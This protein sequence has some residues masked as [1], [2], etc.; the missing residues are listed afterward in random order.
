VALITGAG[1]RR[2]IAAAVARRL[3][4][5]GWDLGL[6]WWPAGD[7]G[8]PWAGP[9]GEPLELAEELGLT[10]RVAWHEADLADPAAPATLFDAIAG[11]LGPVQALVCSHAR[12]R[13]GGVLDT[14]A[15]DFDAHVA[16]NARATLLLIR[17]LASRLPAGVP[18]RVVS[19]TSDALHGEVAYGASKAALE[20]VTVAAAIE[21]APRGITVNAVKPGPDRHGLDDRG[22]RAAAGAAHPGGPD[23]PARRRCGAG[24]LPLLAV[25]PADR[26]GSI[27]TIATTTERTESFLDEFQ[28]TLP[29]PLDPFQREAIEKLDRHVG[30]LVSAPTS[31]GKTVVA[32]YCNFRALR[33]GSKVIYTTPLKALSNQKF[34]DFQRQY[35]AA[36]VG[37]VTGENTINDDAPIVVMT[38]EILRNLIYEDVER[39][40]LVRYVVLDEVHYID[41]FPRGSVWEEVIIQAPA[42]V[43]FVGLSATIGNYRELARWMSENRGPVATVFHEERPTELR[44]WLAM[45]NRFHPLFNAQ[46]AIEQETWARAA[47]DDE[48]ANL[49]GDY[50]RLP[51]NDM[52]RVIDELRRMEML[53]A[54]YF[55]FSRRGCR[56]AL[57]RCSYHELD[58]TSDEEKR[59]IDRLTSERLEALLDADEAALFRRMVDGN[60]LR[61]GLAVHHAGLLPYHKE[62]VEELF[63]AGLVKVVFATETL[64]LGINMPAKAVV[65][66]SFTKFDGVSFSTLTT[67]ELTQL[68]GRAGRRGIDVRGHGVILKEQDVDIATIY[69]VAMGEGLVVESKFLP[70]YNMALNLL[71]L[72]TPPQAEQLML[73]SFGQYQKRLASDQLRERI[74]NVRSRLSDLDATWDCDRCRPSE[75]GEYYQLED[76]LRAVRIEVRRLRR[77]AV[78]VPRRK[79]GHG[80]YRGRPHGPAGRQLHRLE[81]ERKALQERQ[82]KLA[83]VRCP[84]FTEHLARYGERRE[85]ERELREGE[86]ALAEQGDL[87]Q[88]KFRRLCRVL[89]DTGFIEGDKPTEKGLLAARVYGENS[90]LVT[91]A[92][93]LGWFDGLQPEELCALMVMLTAE[94][95]GRDRGPRPQR[96]SPTPAI[97]QTARLLR[98]LYFRFA[99]LESDLDEP[100]LRPPSHDYIDFAYRWASGEPMDSIPLPPNV[101]IGDAIK[102][103]KGLYS[104]LRQTEFALRAADSPLRPTVGAAVERMERDVIRRT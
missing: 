96:R 62:L 14:T 37:L 7:A 16:V 65:V 73:R 12:S 90:L 22:R 47:Q 75:I 3:A 10:V 50:R 104:M 31:S 101:D 24:R 29:W 80:G 5:E 33:E 61:R 6:S 77:E 35:G 94:D 9:P 60:M 49:V 66:S 70:N 52:L 4:A 82:R 13:R 2:G 48:A 59:A 84:N 30:V 28:Q 64:S 63:A 79:R 99:D 1:R 58:L 69:E 36:R 95:R 39:L 34:H 41:D 89:A 74:A 53:P 21:L 17:E 25:R 71:R 102:A 100:N 78:P 11:R 98:S 44:L 87:Y 56:E 27:K 20:R 68:M 86:R 55:I 42:H 46:G 67:G 43:R 85:L 93:W 19:L 26:L 54:I 76:R 88:R 45:R 40:D 51:S 103:M 97:A 38:T 15:E 91:E 23:R 32:D 57:Q 8:L 72:Y 92:I 18:G 83:V 81:E